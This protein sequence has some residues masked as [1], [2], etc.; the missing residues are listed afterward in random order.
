VR[1]DGVGE[2]GLAVVDGALEVIEPLRYGFLESLL[3]VFGEDGVGLVVEEAA[4]E[5]DGG[6]K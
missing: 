4:V 5:V 3:G 1:F 6:R 2:T